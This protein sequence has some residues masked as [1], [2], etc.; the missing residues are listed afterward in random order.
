L[1]RSDIFWSDRHG[2]SRLAQ[3]ESLTERETPNSIG[4][5][6]MRFRLRTL[7]I[8]L[9]VAPM[10]IAAGW[11]AIKTLTDSAVFFVVLGIAAGIPLVFRAI[12][13]R[14]I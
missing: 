8:V 11:W 9:G 14:S 6:P 5:S 7:L 3:S 12:K 1:G 13:A 4:F 2:N 10:V